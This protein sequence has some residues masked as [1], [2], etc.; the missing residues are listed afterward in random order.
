MPNRGRV[1]SS[2]PAREWTHSVCVCVCPRWLLW[3]SD[4]WEGDRLSLQHRR[5]PDV[6]GQH[7]QL[8]RPGTATIKQNKMTLIRDDPS[9]A[10][11]TSGS[12]RCVVLY[13]SATETSVADI[14]SEQRHTRSVCVLQLY[15]VLYNE[16]AETV[17]SRVPAA[18]LTLSCN[19]NV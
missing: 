7:C 19:V 12:N 6:L 10:S 4:G 15:E 17:Q 3:H 2:R 18:V 1:L 14:N 11:I 16:T 8:P 5:E 13:E 9:E